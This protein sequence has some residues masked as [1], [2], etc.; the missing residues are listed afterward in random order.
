[1]EEYWQSPAEAFE[2]W[3]RI[4]GIQG[5]AYGKTAELLRANIAEYAGS[6]TSE[7]GSRLRR[8]NLK[9]KNAPGHAS[10]MQKMQ[11]TFLHLKLL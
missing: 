9:L 5:I 2:K 6:I 3:K 1:V 10:I 7:M 4:P 8:Q 11:G